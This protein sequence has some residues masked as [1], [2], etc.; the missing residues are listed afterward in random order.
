MCTQPCNGLSSD[1]PNVDVLCCCVLSLLCLLG[2]V[3]TSNME[4]FSSSVFVKEWLLERLLTETAAGLGLASSNKFA[5]NNNS[6]KPCCFF[7]FFFSRVP[8]AR[9]LR[10][11]GGARKSNF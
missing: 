11:K 6:N 10:T 1:L 7:L 5:N 4:F 8:L 9:V 3:Y 2:P